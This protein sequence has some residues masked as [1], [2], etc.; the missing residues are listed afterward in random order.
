MIKF[1][2]KKG[3]TVKVPYTE[4]M[5]ISFEKYLSM[6]HFYFYEYVINFLKTFGV[7]EDITVTTFSRIIV[8]VKNDNNTVLLVSFF[9][10]IV[11]YDCIY[12]QCSDKTT[13]HSGRTSAQ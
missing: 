4:Y 13:R 8:A 9:A 3:G 12:A 5:N 11:D 6:C 7:F 1:Q 10:E 2:K